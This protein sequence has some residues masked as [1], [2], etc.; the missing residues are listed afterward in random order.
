[1]PGT[2]KREN[3][4]RQIHEISFKVDDQLRKPLE[5]SNQFL[6]RGSRSL[7][8]LVHGLIS[9]CLETVDLEVDIE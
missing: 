3:V 1:M 9:E 2:N 7:L 5:R 8:C 4:L 6:T